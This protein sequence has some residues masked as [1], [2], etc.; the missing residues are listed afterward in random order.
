MLAR[1]LPELD[2]F[3]AWDLSFVNV[4]RENLFKSLQ[5]RGFCPHYAGGGVLPVR[6]GLV[7]VEPRQR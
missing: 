4:G 7:G 2:A 5:A 3:Y 1:L 6:G